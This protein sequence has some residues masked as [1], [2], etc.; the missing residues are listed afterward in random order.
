MN[1]ISKVC[2]A[3]VKSKH[4]KSNFQN[5]DYVLTKRP[6]ELLLIDLFGPIKIASLG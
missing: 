2:E 1:T 6:L 3:C 4:V 5:K